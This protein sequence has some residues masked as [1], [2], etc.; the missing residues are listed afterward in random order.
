MKKPSFKSYDDFLKRWH[1]DVPEHFNFA[2]DVVDQIALEDPQRRAL[3][4]V[5]DMDQRTEYDFAFFSRESARLAKGLASKGLKKGDRVMLILYRRVEFW[6]TVLALH[7][8]GAVAIPSPA[9]LTVKDIEYRLN[10]AD[11]RGVIADHSVT[12]LV[13]EARE[14]FPSCRIVVEL[15]GD[16][17]RRGWLRYEDVCAAG[18]ALATPLQRVAGG[19]DPLF[20]FFSSGTTGSPKMVMHDHTYPA[21]HTITAAC[22]QDLRPGDLHM[23]IADTGWAKAAWGKLY[24]QWMAGATV[25]VYD[26]RG[27]FNAIRLLK[28]LSEHRVT[29]FCAP[30]TVYRL[31][32]THHD[33]HKFDLSSLRHCTSAGELL[34]HDIFD[35][36]KKA[37]GISIYEGYGQTET[38]L[39]IATFPFMKIKP[40]SIGRPCPG[41]DVVLLDENDQPVP[42]KQEAEICI[43]LNGKRLLGL[44]NGYLADDK[45]SARVTRDGF[46][47]TGDK[48]WMDEDGYFWFLGR[49]DD[50]IKSSGYRI[51]PFEVES[52]LVT[53]PAVAEAAVTGVPDAVRGQLVKATLVLKPG[54]EPSEKLIHELQDHVKSITA[55]YKYP[56]VIEFVEELPKTISG[57]IRRAEIRNRDHARHADPSA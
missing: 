51:G 30:P 53:H 49:T 31:M 6:T 48:A 14:A 8:L 35:A 38:T 18:D 10:A 13:E 56:R 25:F 33:L 12:G 29:T 34:N 15:G 24:G 46:Y 2:F 9:M 36:W 37:T 7:K 28:V 19:S 41:W 42:P 27:R 39:Q 4:H 3:V 57:K 55:S 11:V 16:P 45:L 52:A 1:I 26:F 54:F 5:D 44:F 17:T 23:T 43:R 32:I 47:R 20:I 40:G 22:W 21:A 50:L